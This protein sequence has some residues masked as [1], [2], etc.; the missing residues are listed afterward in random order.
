M[1]LLD[2][3]DGTLVQAPPLSRTY[4]GA[5]KDGIEAGAELRVPISDQEPKCPGSIIEGHEEVA[6]TSH[7]AISAQFTPSRSE[8]ARQHDSLANLVA[9]IRSE[10]VHPLDTLVA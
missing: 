4:P 2:S 3:L 5:S 10:I 9:H 1:V 8:R 6:T 7:A